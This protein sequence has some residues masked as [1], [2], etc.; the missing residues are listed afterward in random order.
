MT[1]ALEEGSVLEQ[2]V[3]GLAVMKGEE[4]ENMMQMYEAGEPREK[5]ER[6]IVAGKATVERLVE[7][8]RR[9]VA[10]PCRAHF[11]SPGM[12]RD[13]FEFWSARRQSRR[14]HGREA[15]C[16]VDDVRCAP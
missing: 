5:R 9:E 2:L 14:R 13:M 10:H 15:C 7:D 6:N 3:R 8:N 4:R 1:Q 11:R 16:M 12:L